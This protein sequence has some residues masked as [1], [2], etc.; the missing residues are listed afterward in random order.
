M[1]ENATYLRRLDL[2]GSKT[3]TD[4]LLKVIKGKKVEDKVTR[5]CTNSDRSS[6]ICTEAGHSAIGNV[7]FYIQPL[8]LL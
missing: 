1:S 3:V 6:E 2:T 7:N 4:D 5:F 8:P